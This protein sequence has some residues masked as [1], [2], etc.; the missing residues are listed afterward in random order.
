MGLWEGVGA[1]KPQRA[2]ADSIV[3]LQLWGWGEPFGI[4]NRRM[5]DSFNV[6][7]IAAL[8]VPSAFALHFSSF[9]L[10]IWHPGT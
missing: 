10:M 1:G 9:K 4:L 5:A 2:V 3:A 8:G 7:Q 6:P